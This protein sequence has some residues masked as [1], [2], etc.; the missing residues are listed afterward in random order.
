MGISF[1]LALESNNQESINSTRRAQPFSVQ[2]CVGKSVFSVE[3]AISALV[4]VE[5]KVERLCFEED[6]RREGGG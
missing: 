4:F 2:Q 5:R 6:A 3:N 1:R